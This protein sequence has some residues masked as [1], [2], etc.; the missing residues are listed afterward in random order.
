VNQ[1]IAENATS[2]AIEE[3]VHRVIDLMRENL[4]ENLTVDDMARVAMYSKFHFTRVFQRVTGMSPGR[5][6][7][8]LRLK[9]AKRLLLSTEL[10]V[11]EISY[12]VGYSSIGT[13]GSRFTQAVGMSPSGYRRHGRCAHAAEVEDRRARERFRTVERVLEWA[14]DMARHGGVARAHRI[15]EAAARADV[16]PRIGPAGRGPTPA[17]RYQRRL[18]IAAANRADR[19]HPHAIHVPLKS[20]SGRYS[21]PSSRVPGG[22][23][24]PATRSERGSDGGS[25]N[26]PTAPSG[27]FVGDRSPHTRP[28]QRINARAGSRGAPVEPTAS[29]EVYDDP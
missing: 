11:T 9:E 17:Q 12:R 2:I 24:V 10:P 20:E 29:R 1:P 28:R 22:E 7:S 18:L 6:L 8:A 26:G 19:H 5:F 23:A 27:R 15:A 13:F 25:P 3:A 4:G 14:T 21:F 16:L